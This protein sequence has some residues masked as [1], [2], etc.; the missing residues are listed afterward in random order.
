M[1]CTAHFRQRTQTSTAGCSFFN[2]ITA[3]SAQNTN[4]T[5]IFCRVIP[6]LNNSVSSVLNFSSVISSVLPTWNGNKNH[7]YQRLLSYTLF[8]LLEMTTCADPENYVRGA[9]LWSRKFCQ[10]GPNF[11]SEKF[12]RGGTTLTFFVVF[13]KL[14]KGGSIQIPL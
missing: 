12:I 4:N 14:M 10:R 5:T 7:E 13:F 9:Q 1:N 2:D 8:N 3:T 6:P 11:D